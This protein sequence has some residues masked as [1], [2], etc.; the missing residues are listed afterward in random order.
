MLLWGR[1]V[2]S[3]GRAR[4]GRHLQYLP[5]QQRLW[6]FRQLTIAYG[7]SEGNRAADLI[8]QFFLQEVLNG[9][10]L[11][12]AA[13][14]ARQRFIQSATMLDPTDVK[15]LAQFNLLGDPS[16]HPVQPAHHAL[17]R[18]KVFHT[19]FQRT[20][21]LTA[22]R[23]LRREQ[24]V[25]NGLMAQTAGV[26]KK[27][28]AIRPPSKVK[29]IL[30]QAARQSKLTK[31]T[32][33]SFAIQVPVKDAVKAAKLRLTDSATVHLVIGS[34][35]TPDSQRSPHRRGGGHGGGRR[36]SAIAAPPQPEHAI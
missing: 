5:A 10:S 6:I 35:R 29:R 13:L 23:A 28:P 15:T 17:S 26:A 16:I 27:K 20:D 34:R 2:Q 21:G 11:G 30:Q 19:A 24:L 36:G 7:P 3:G 1:A 4:A 8:C 12:L 33:A 31:F 18:T 9:A 14:V 32:T 22:G 25:R